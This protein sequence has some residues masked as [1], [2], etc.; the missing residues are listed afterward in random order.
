MRLNVKN[1]IQNLR[2]KGEA[3]RLVFECCI[4]IHLYYNTVHGKALM[5]YKPLIEPFSSLK[6]DR[7]SVYVTVSVV[8]SMLHILERDLLKSQDT[9]TPV[10][11]D[12]KS[13]S[14]IV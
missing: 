9:E 3:I 11:K 4:H 7:Y 10:T 13:L 5:F 8:L 14:N 6:L 1:G 2:A 12:I